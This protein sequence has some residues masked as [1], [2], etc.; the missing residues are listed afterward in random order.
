[1]V[2][3]VVRKSNIGLLLILTIINRWRTQ[4]V[5][6]VQAYPQAYI[7]KEVY[8][9]IANGMEI[10]GKDKNQ[11]VLMIHKNIYGQKQVGRVW[12]KYLTDKLM[13]EVGF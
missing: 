8:M 5:D 9:E 7:K 12:H 2:A 6:Y 10:K 11:Y 13:S 3:A 4:Q 1:M